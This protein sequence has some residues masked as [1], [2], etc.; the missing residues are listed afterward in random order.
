MDGF[1]F[2]IRTCVCICVIEKFQFASIACTDWVNAKANSQQVTDWRSMFS[3]NL[4]MMR[5]L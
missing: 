3:T 1:V 2:D 5:E 4:S